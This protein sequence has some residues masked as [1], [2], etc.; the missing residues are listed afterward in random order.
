MTSDSDR[1]PLE[2]ALSEDAAHRLLARAV[3][4]DARRA[5]DVSIAELREIAREAGIATEAFDE[6]LNE[7]RA[8]F[9][10][11]VI[12]VRMVSQVSRSLG[13]D[14]PVHAAGRV[15]G[16]AR[17]ECDRHARRHRRWR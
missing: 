6:A 15:C 7:M 3:E 5:S 4:L 9:R 17:C 8:D 2:H 11:L 14:W 16:Y 13:A 10:F 12:L 1:P